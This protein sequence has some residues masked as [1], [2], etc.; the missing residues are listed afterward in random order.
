MK[1]RIKGNSLRYRLT[2]SE[3]KRFC[4]SGYFEEIIRFGNTEL[5]Y[6]LK[7]TFAHKLSAS[8]ND[9]K[10][11]VFMPT[12]MADEWANTAR[13]GFE[14]NEGEVYLLVEKDFVCLDTVNEDQSDN[15]PNPLL[16][17]E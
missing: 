9:N 12:V 7:K 17:K 14:S 5:I 1:L 15:Y 4:D 3:V 16:S 6:A 13:V 8:F 10:I 11:T 2:R